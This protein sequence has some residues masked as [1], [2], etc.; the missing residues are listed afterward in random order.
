[1]KLLPVALLSG[2][3]L[4]AAV[5]APTVARASARRGGT[6]TV[7]DETDFEHLDP[8]EAYYSLDYSVLNAT[9]RP[10]YSYG[11]GGTNEIGDLAAGPPQISSDLRTVTVELRRGIHFSPPVNREV[12]SADVAYAIERGAN[13]HVA[14]PYIEAYFGAVEGMPKARGGRVKGILTPNP[15]EIVFKL[16]APLGQLVADALVMPLTA[17]VPERY[18]RRFDAHKPSTYGAHEVGTGPYMIEN[19]REGGVLGVGYA[20]GRSLT[21]VRNPNWRRDTDFRPAYVNRIQV[22]IGGSNAV[23]NL[24]VLGR[25]DT[26][27]DEPPARDVIR[28]ALSHDP[29]QVIETPGAGSDYVGVNAAVAPF[30]NIDLRKALWAALDRQEMVDVRG[31]AGALSSVA[32]H[33]LYPGIPGFEEAGGL[34]GPRGPQFDFDEHP[35][36]DLA[37]AESYIRQAGYPSGR[38]T[39]KTAVVI[40]GALG[41]PAQKDAEIVNETLIKLGFKTKFALVETATMYAR[42]CNV[43]SKEINICPDVGWVADFDDPQPVLDITF[44]GNF[45]EPTGNVNWGQTNVPSINQEMFAAEVLAGPARDAAWARIDDHLVEDAASIPFDWDLGV[46]LEGRRVDGVTDA[47]NTGTF[48][49]NFTSLR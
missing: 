3:L 34:Q 32:S 33:F 10:L 37:L 28:F 16:T 7:L 48:D 18:A 26:V 13:P 20:P 40:V 49:F 12:T 27:D 29:H 47:W 44:N 22:R 6:L 19:N 2:L 23:D 8:G 46:S 24:R 4:L 39:G 5:S 30:S 43:P 11:P 31:V 38:Y 36:G 41:E 1:M 45:I 15:R 42:Y 25:T 14:N 9:Q 35:E 21:L 17:P